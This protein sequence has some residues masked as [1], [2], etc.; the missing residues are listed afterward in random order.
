MLSA[1]KNFGVTFLISALLFGILAYFG[2]LFVTRTVN[3]ILEDD[4]TELTSIIQT[5]EAPESQTEETGEIE[6]PGEINPDIPLP[7]G[8]SFNFLVVANDYR[9]DLYDDYTPDAAT[10]AEATEGL[11]NAVPTLGMLSARFREVNATAIVLVRA[12]RD[13]RQ[14]VYTYFTPEMEVYTPSGYQTLSWIYSN[15]GTEQLSEYINAMTGLRISYTL[16]VDGFR[17]DELVKILG[18]VTVNLPRDIYNDGS[19]ITMEYETLIERI[20]DDGY[21]WTEHVPNQ[22]LIGAGDCTVTEDNL[23][24]LNLAAEHTEADR[25]AKQTYTIAI[26]REYL[27]ALLAA[28]K[29]DAEI[30]LRALITEPSAWGS[31][32]GFDA[33]VIG[34]V[35]AEAEEEETE[36]EEEELP[37]EIDPDL[38]FDPTPMEEV[39]VSEEQPEEEKEPEKLW[40]QPLYEPDTAVIATNFTLADFEENYEMLAAVSSF[41]NVNLTYPC[42]YTPAND[43]NEERFEVRLKDGLNLFSS[44][45]VVGE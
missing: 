43:A 42:T 13:K 21:P 37:F 17:L 24:T 34:T 1:F 27:R 28:D 8:K 35:T 10:V 39:P 32:S 30:L 19:E 41:E 12:D 31:I 18:N 15:Y 16:T 2:S 40:V 6:E 3:D 5:G 25:D 20:G 22:W 33:P 26:V 14:Y 7:D 36:E 11:E 23:Y 45:R 9:P 38:P 44:Y 4:D 29:D